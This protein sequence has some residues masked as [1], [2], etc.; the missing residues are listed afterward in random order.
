MKV[1]GNCPKDY[2]CSSTAG[3]LNSHARQAISRFPLAHTDHA[4]CHC[5][6]DYGYNEIQN[7][8]TSYSGKT[9]R[10]IELY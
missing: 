10:D 2:K 1:K 6:R 4:L 9:Y 3:Q 7:N 8:I 5:V